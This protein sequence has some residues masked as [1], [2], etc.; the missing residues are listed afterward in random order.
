MRGFW[1]LDR[2][3][4][5]FALEHLAHPSLPSEFA[6]EIVTV[7]VRHAAQ[8][9]DYSLALAY[10]Y[11]TQ[12]VF[13]T[14]EALELLFGAL[15]R[16]SVTEALYFS[17]RQPDHARQQLFERLV[18]T[19]LDRPETVGARAKELVSQPLMADEEKWLHDYLTAGDGKK[20]KSARLLTQMREIVTG[21]NRGPV[22]Q[23]TG[24]AVRAS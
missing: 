16:T 17:R 12:P 21:R 15:A 11:T 2:T 9:G 18:A 4:F 24:N 19:V 6:D 3:E 22:S 14:P 23:W 5:K 1:H 7:L 20:S 13:K 10:Y 8:G